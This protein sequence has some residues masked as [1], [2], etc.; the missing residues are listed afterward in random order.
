L[1]RDE[2]QKEEI[3]QLHTMFAQMKNELEKGYQESRVSLLEKIRRL[4]KNR[5]FKR[6]NWA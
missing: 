1:H 3:I 5:A 6:K 2:M 4:F